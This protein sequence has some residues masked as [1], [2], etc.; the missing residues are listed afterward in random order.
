MG[1]NRKA[2]DSEPPARPALPRIPPIK[3][4]GDDLIKI[5]FIRRSVGPS[6]LKYPV[7]AESVRGGLGSTVKKKNEREEENDK[8]KKKTEKR[9]IRGRT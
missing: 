4:T 5:Y 7:F 8:R 6:R 9:G 3:D 1:V 2:S